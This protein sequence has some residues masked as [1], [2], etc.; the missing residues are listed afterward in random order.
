M[1]L[2][3]GTDVGKTYVSARIVK[4]LKSQ[5]KVGYYKA[6]LSGAV[7]ENDVLIPGDLEVVKQYASLPNEAVKY[8]L[9]MKKHLRLI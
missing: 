3:T 1:L 2:E 4:A 7:V 6:A 8:L 5:Y 9:F